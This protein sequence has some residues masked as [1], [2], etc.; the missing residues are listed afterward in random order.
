MIGRIGDRR[1]HWIQALVISLVLHGAAAAAMLDVLP[2]LPEKQRDRDLPQIDIL[3]LPIEQG[4]PPPVSVTPVEPLVAPVA[5]PAAIASAVPPPVTGATTAEEPPEQAEQLVVTPSD[6]MLQA[7]TGL[8]ERPPRRP[9]T[10]QQSI[11]PVTPDDQPRIGVDLAA[12]P[13]GMGAGPADQAGTPE[14]NAAITDLVQRLRGRLAQPC[15][16][17]LPQTIGGDEVLLTVLGAVD[18]DI[19]DLFRDIAVDVAVPMTERSVLLDPRQCPAVDFARAAASYPALPLTLRLE[20]SEVASD[21]RLIGQIEGVGDNQA[22]LLMIDDNGVVQ[23][24]RRFT[25]QTG[26]VI[27]FDVPVYRVGGDRDTSQLLMV[28]ALPERPTSIGAMAGRLASDFFPPLTEATAGRALI[29]VA[30]IY[31]RAPR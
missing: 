20:T 30:P 5:T 2:S 24:L 19:S 13:P 31:V 11:E 14:Q 12:L 17:A 27:R 8:A 4:A 7:T 18:R 25:L 29:G 3:S 28:V 15:L 1:G 9:L 6:E 22:S 26:D 21:D 16:A 23:D 10:D